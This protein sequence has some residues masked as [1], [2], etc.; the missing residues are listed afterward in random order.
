MLC[1]LLRSNERDIFDMATECL[2]DYA[3]RYSR[4]HLTEKVEILNAIKLENMH[5]P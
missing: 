5:D 4:S 2:D 3:H 1:K